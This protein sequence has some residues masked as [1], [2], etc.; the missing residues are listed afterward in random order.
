[1]VTSIQAETRKAVE[2]MNN[3]CSRVEMGVQ[4]A[5]GAGTALDN[6]I[7]GSSGA[8]KMMMQIATSATQ[9]STATEQ[10]TQNM[11]RIAQMVE[12]SSS[13]AEQSA[14]AIQDLSSQATQLQSLVGQFKVDE[15]DNEAETRSFP[16]SDRDF[17]GTGRALYQ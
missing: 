12:Q 9:Q 10:V 5:L 17:S 7:E 13:A 6:I 2:A 1:M 3:S 15:Y 11:D 8:Q 14:K 16:T 4:K